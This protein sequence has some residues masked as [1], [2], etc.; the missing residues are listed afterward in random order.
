MKKLVSA[1]LIA[2]ILVFSVFPKDKYDNIAD[3]ACNSVTGEKLGSSKKDGEGLSTGT[4]I[5]IGLGLAAVAGG[6][7]LAATADD[8]YEK[9]ADK[10]YEASKKE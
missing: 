7:I 9:I 3:K 10:A 2:C 4:K 5:G 6:I 1:A 8:K